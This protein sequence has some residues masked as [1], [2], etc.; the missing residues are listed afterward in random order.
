MRQGLGAQ[1]TTNSADRPAERVDFGK[2]IH[3]VMEQST[4][5]D[6]TPDSRELLEQLWARQEIALRRGGIF[7]ST[8]D[9]VAPARLAAEER[10]QGM[11]VGIAVGDSLGH[12]TEWKFDPEL[13]HQKFGTIVDHVPDGEGRLGRIS[14]DTQM[15]FWTVERLLARG[16]FDFDDLVSCFVNRRNKIVGR[17]R[18]TAAALERH[19]GRLRGE[20]LTL[21]DCLGDVRQEGRGN[22]GLMRIA[23]MVLPHLRSSSRSLWSDAALSTF[24]THGN[25]FALAASIGFVDLLW[26]VLRM[27]LGQAPEPL[28]WIDRYLQVTSDLDDVLPLPVQ[29]EP[30]PKWFSSFRGTMGEFLAGPV[31]DGFVKGVPLRDACSQE[32][33]G[34]RAD[35]LQTIPACLYVLMCHADSFQSA[36]IASINDTKDNDTVA[37]IVGAIL[38]ALHGKRAIRRK[39]IEGIGS[40]VLEIPAHQSASDRDV[41]LSMADRAASE[42]L[43]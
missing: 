12:S 23:P 27:P 7:D 31:R 6:M 10:I 1:S 34:S 17:G 11:L 5:F 37:A 25:A 2:V 42:F 40:R 8:P 33:F 3:T 41:I 15:S 4:L 32:G 14:D 35:C 18:N 36:V 19:S 26:H 38:G 21:G 29:S 13:R 22:G 43:S 20:R 24:I 30:M 39:W 9:D 28:W 16:Q